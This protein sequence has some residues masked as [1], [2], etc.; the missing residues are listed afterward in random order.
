MYDL[1]CGRSGFFQL[2][3]INNETAGKYIPAITC[4]K[5][6][7]WVEEV[8]TLPNVLKDKHAQYKLG[9]LM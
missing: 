5:G 7:R 3:T 6:D 2:V 4:T 9:L 1:V 8:P